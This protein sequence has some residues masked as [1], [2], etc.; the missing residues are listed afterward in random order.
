M[1]NEIRATSRLYRRIRKTTTPEQGQA[2][3]IASNTLFEKKSYRLSRSSK[4]DYLLGFRVL[5]RTAKRWFYHSD[6]T[7][8]AHGAEAVVVGGTVANRDIIL[9]Y[10]AASSGK[11]ALSF[12]PRD[13]VGFQNLAGVFSLFHFLLF[14]TPIACSAIFSKR[15]DNLSLVISSVAEIS[16]VKA[17]LRAHGVK[18]VFDF[19]SF[20]SDSNFMYLSLHEESV[21]VCKIPSSGPLAGH[22]LKTLSDDFV[23]STPYQEE[24]IAALGRDIVYSNILRW[25]PERAHTYYEKFCSIRP[26]IPKQVLGYYSHG[27]WARN[28]AGHAEYGTGVEE[29]ENRILSFIRNYCESRPTVIVSVYPHPKEL[30]KAIIARTIEFYDRTLGHARY[31]LMQ[32]KGGSAQHFDKVNVAIASY[33]TIIYERLYCGMKILISGR[34]KLGFPL[35]NSKLN[36]ICFLEQ[37]DFDK[38]LD[39]ALNQTEEDFFRLNKL[40]AYLWNNFPSPLI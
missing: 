32:V 18:Y 1:T 38:K 29:D 24:E 9:R 28:V 4:K 15:R 5:W 11:R 6:D 12:I 17:Y 35:E 19:Y 22:Y 34:S 23:I 26:I 39:E 37:Q 30:D 14:A 27:Q 7:F 8:N 3:W 10:V 2:L 40:E 16:F 33:S 13:S 20:E 21:R 36:N 31:E 25:P